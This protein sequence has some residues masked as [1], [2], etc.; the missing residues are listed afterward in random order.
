M[1]ISVLTPTFNRA[2]TL[3]SL[4]NSLLINKQYA[5]LEW[6]IMDD[7]STDNTEELINSWIKEDKINIVY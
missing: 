2:Y 7:G 4:Y 5:D 3:T 6:L 1:K